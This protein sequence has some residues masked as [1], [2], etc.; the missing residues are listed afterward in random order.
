[1]F[2]KELTMTGFCKLEKDSKTFHILN[3]YNEDLLK[4]QDIFNEDQKIQIEEI[5]E[6]NKRCNRDASIEWVQKYGK[7]ERT[8]L[9]TIKFLY[10][11]IKRKQLQINWENFCCCIE[12]YNTNWFPVLTETETKNLLDRIF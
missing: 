8:Y 7:G 4:H 5:I 9:N 2:T 6:H 10:V 11:L 1:M 3:L 12:D